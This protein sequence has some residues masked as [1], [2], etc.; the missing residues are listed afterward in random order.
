MKNILHISDLHLS[1]DPTKG[2][3]VSNANSVA[4]LIC[5]DL[6]TN[7]DG[8][9]DTVFITG[10][11]SFSGDVSAFSTI[12]EVFILPLL[13]KLGLTIDALYVVPGNH[14][15]ERSS[16]TI[17]ERSMIK[18]SKDEDFD[19]L[20]DSIINGTSAWPR[21]NNYCEFKSEIVSRQNN[22]I[23]DN[24]LITVYRAAEGLNVHCV[25]SAWLATDDSD[26]GNLRILKIL[27]R[28]FDKYKSKVNVLLMHH[29]L[30][31]LHDSERRSVSRELEK[32]VDA[33]FYGHMHEFEQYV[34]IN[35][36]QDIC[37]KVQ[38]GTLDTRGD[39]SGYSYIKLHSNNNF[40]YGVIN[41]RKHD[42]VGNKFEPWVERALNGVSDFSLD[43]R[44]IFDSAKFSELSEK[45]LNEV[46]YSHVI[47]IGLTRESSHR[48]SRIFIEPK[49]TQNISVDILDS[50]IKRLNSFSE[51]QSLNGLAIITG[52]QQDGKTTLLRNIQ[53]FHLQ[54]QVNS[55]FNKIVFYIDASKG[56]S[57]KSQVLMGFI[58]SYLNH[59]LQTSFESKIKSCIK[60]GN[61]IFL[62]DN[63]HKADLESCKN[64][65][66]FIE[67]NQSNSF[68][69]TSDSESISKTLARARG[70][71]CGDKY[72]ASI[73]AIARVD[74]RKIISLRPNLAKVLSEDEV[75]NNVVRLVDNSQLPHNHFVYSILLVI[76][77]SKNELVGIVSEADIIENYI[78]IL[79]H[80]HCFDNSSSKP[81]YKVLLHFMGFFSRRLLKDKKLCFNRNDFFKIALEFESLT[82]H[83]YDINDYLLPVIKSG[84]V[85]EKGNSTLEF[86]NLCFFY[87]FIAYYMKLDE[88]LKD[89]VFLSDNYLLLD[90]VVEYYSSLNSSSFDVL[91]FLCERL[92]SIKDKVLKDVKACHDIDLNEIE[93]NDM[94]EISFLD[95]AS[96]VDDVE[97]KIEEVRTDRQHYDEDLDRVS[98]LQNKRVSKSCL[99]ELDS[100][101]EE[102]QKNLDLSLRYKRELSLLSR[103]F[104]NTELL[105]DPAKVMNVFDFIVGSYV[106][107]IKLE[108]TRLD[109][110]I[111]MPLLLPQIEEHIEDD[112]LTDRAKE[113]LIDAVKVFL[114]VIRASIPNIIEQTMSSDLST[115]KPRFLNI[116]NTK[117]ENGSS[118]TEEM[119]LRFLLLGIERKKFREHISE[120]LNCTGQFTTNTLFLKLLQLL[121]ERHDFTS[122]DEKYLKKTI[123]MMIT[124]KKGL[125]TDAFVRFLKNIEDKSIDKNFLN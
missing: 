122:D 24:P 114:S 50:E 5:D 30:D 40:D 57:T 113:K 64:I 63:Y 44:M 8:E 1:V 76:Y 39:N 58:D 19:L 29:P 120:L 60:D 17:P 101:F 107:L 43:T 37:L 66:K 33:M 96:S 14:D 97:K 54:A 104:R 70:L 32:K 86:S 102:H 106:F 119:L 56:Y 85:I 68:L 88:E 116:L 82:F 15:V 9:V 74:I 79:L 2:F 92:L 100:S 34:T 42:N 38:A 94:S 115:R 108:V 90:K 52:S 21:L 6:N 7:F 36:S 23:F 123:R 59:D 22:V 98:P 110:D 62:I 125:N 61:A 83:K 27:K 87:Y 25:N 91:S 51:L 46:E 105:M 65:D 20:C 93:L 4:E 3:N 53:L 10:D 18:N 121:H 69:I 48:L 26:K 117:I 16:I 124:A 28:S 31:W 67:E 112:K 49:L 71:Y 84:I 12:I 111:V 109:E 55:N 118:P 41:Y 47:N 11:I 95:I 77:E 103:V 80:K 45:I 35:I 78:E 13:D 81:S 75:F 99:N 72:Y 73:G 89:Y